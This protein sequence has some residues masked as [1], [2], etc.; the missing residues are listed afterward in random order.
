MPANPRTTAIFYDGKDKVTCNGQIAI[1]QV[2]VSLPVCRCRLSKTNVTST[3]DFGQSFTI[4]LGSGFPKR[5][6]NTLHCLSV[7]LKTIP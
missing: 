5:D 3:Y 2:T 1:T 7:L 4:P 6:F